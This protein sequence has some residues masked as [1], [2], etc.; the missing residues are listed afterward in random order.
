M[1][2]REIH[3]CLLTWSNRCIIIFL[4]SLPLLTC[5]RSAMLGWLSRMSWS[6]NCEITLK[7]Q[8]LHCWHRHGLRP[9]WFI[10]SWTVEAKSNKRTCFWV[11]TLIKLLLATPWPPKPNFLRSQYAI[12][13][14]HFLPINPGVTCQTIKLINYQPNFILVGIF[15]LFK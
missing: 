11:E 10:K 2:F 14:W 8:S 1:I 5:L 12:K 15:C 3:F 9:K 7:M 4:H 13:P 6:S